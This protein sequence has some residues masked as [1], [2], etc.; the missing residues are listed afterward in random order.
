MK[1]M[2]FDKKKFSRIII[3][4]GEFFLVCYLIQAIENCVAAAGFSVGEYAALVFAG[5][6][7]FEDGE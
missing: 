4:I 3:I 1:K 6:M 5:A 2:T 7:S